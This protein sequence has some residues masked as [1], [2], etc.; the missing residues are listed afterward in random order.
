MTP[1][2]PTVLSAVILLFLFT[3]DLFADVLV[4]K[5]GGR[6]EGTIVE[7]TEEHIV[8]DVPGVGKMTYARKGVREILRAE[9]GP[10]PA[11]KGER[12]E[13]KRIE[14]A[15]IWSGDR[16]QGTRSL[17]VRRMEDGSLRLE[18]RIIYFDA[19]GVEEARVFL[20][21]HVDA[22]LEPKSLVYRELTKDGSPLRSIRA[23]VRGGS[24][25]LSISLPGERVES[26]HSLPEGV[27]F[28]LSAREQIFR[29]HKRIK[30]DYE[31]AVYD[32][33][34]EN[35]YRNTFTVLPT[36]QENWEGK[37]LDVVVIRRRR[38][39][40]APE[41]IW[42]N[43]TGKVLM[44][45]LN[46]PGVVAIRTTAER[47]RAFHEGRKVDASP[48]EARAT[49][50]FVHPEAGF[51]ITK[52]G[53]SWEVRKV[54]GVGGVTDDPVLELHYQPCFAYV[55][56]RVEEG[57]PEGGLLSS[58]AVHMEK[59]FRKASKDFVKVSDGFRKV[60][61]KDACGMV[62]TSTL[63]EEALKSEVVG[64]VHADRTWYVVLA[65]P[66]KYF[67]A[68]QKEF[69]RILA[70]LQFIEDKKPEKPA[71]DTPAPKEDTPADPADPAED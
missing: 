10:T 1:A 43:S 50:L 38:A 58:L 33:R 64:F 36:R 53:M 60:A 49:P 14:D 11:K 30:G 54:R 45:Q 16:R 6:Q 18:E 48:E 62:A 19:K 9:P 46:G 70:S 63:K 69:A 41:E 8:L 7:E 32:P 44:E 2:R 20:D 13:I 35:F 26:K 21:E 37:A 71:E 51:R 28:P 55:D 57:V 40:H 47:L 67:P 15:F 17:R 25:H 34:K 65:A 5:N 12:G 42:L 31:I 59:K 68:A 24:I 4:F 61:G 29:E 27:R 22:A 23:T 56:V 39:G 66:V 52:P 3:P